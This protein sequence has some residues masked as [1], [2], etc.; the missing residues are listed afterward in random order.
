[1]HMTYD[2]KKHSALAMYWREGAMLTRSAQEI[3]GIICL[4]T[5][6][7]TAMAAPTSQPTAPVNLAYDAQTQGAEPIPQSERNLQTVLANPWFTASN[8]G[9]IFEGAIFDRNGNLQS[10]S[11]KLRP[12][13]NGLDSMTSDGATVFHAGAFAHE[14]PQES[15][16]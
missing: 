12:D 1:M 7:D 9:F 16:K 15:T 14:L 5:I 8:E 10:T 3:I 2:F 13:T 4:V 11:L 6:A